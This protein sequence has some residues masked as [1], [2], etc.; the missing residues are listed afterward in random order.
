MQHPLFASLAKAV[1]GVIPSAELQ[2]RSHRSL[3]A[4]QYGIFSQP[5]GSVCHVPAEIAQGP[6][7]LLH[8]E[9]CA[10]SKGRSALCRTSWC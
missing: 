5:D 9:G 10:V 1:R 4:A 7:Y 3:S 6:C 8:V 2:V